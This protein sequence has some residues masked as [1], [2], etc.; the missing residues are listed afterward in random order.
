MSGFLHRVL[1]RHDNTLAPLRR[2]RPS[3]FEAREAAPV[4]MP[5]MPRGEVPS[6][7]GQAQVVHTREIHHHEVAPS[8][9]PMPVVHR[10]TGVE[11]PL[12]APAAPTPGASPPLP[13]PPTL[14]AMPREGLAS[15]ARVI[16]RDT[17]PTSVVPAAVPRRPHDVPREAS[18]RTTRETQRDG[19]A[20]TTAH[21][22]RP[23]SEGLAAAPQASALPLPPRLPQAQRVA[24]PVA[25]PARRAALPAPADTPVQVSIGSV[26]IRAHAPATNAPATRIR[27]A[28]APPLP[29]LDAYL[30]DRH[31]G[32]R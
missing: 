22:P 30:R 27:P 25:H 21:A 9:A 10:Q 8:S 18:T 14:R 3:L 2:R 7:R 11:R 28:A 17:A 6:P 12:P 19:T 4:Q 31:G 24:A 16:A 29:S 15:A 23:T 5:E 20:S 13:M 26:E 32:P 1:T